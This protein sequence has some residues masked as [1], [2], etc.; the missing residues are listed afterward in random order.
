MA[1][2]I[3]HTTSAEVKAVYHTHTSCEEYKKIE[4]NDLKS[5]EICDVCEKLG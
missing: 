4:A 2:T 5:R 1:K 3:Y